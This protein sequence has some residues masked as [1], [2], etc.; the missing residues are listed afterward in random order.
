MDI[1][2]LKMVNQTVH[3]ISPTTTCIFFRKTHLGNYE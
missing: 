3:Y 2:V 1:Y